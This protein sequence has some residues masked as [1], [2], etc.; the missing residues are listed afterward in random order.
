MTTLDTLRPLSLLIVDMCAVHLF[1]GDKADQGVESELDEPEDP[2]TNA[3]R[4]RQGPLVQDAV[5]GKLR[6][7]VLVS[8]R[9]QDKYICK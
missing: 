5:I 9:Q 7:C 8:V 3:K 4:K 1:K 6:V 2:A